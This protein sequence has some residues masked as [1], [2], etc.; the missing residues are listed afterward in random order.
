MLSGV[1]LQQKMGMEEYPSGEGASAAG[2]ATEEADAEEGKRPVRAVYKVML[3][4]FNEKSKIKVRLRH[5]PSILRS[6][7]HSHIRA[8]HA[9][10]VM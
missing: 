2:D 5:V 8:P 4:G 7:F 10:S 9:L 3:T 1:P 6:L